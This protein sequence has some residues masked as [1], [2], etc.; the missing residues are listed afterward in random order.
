MPMAHALGDR[1]AA[2]PGFGAA[3]GAEPRRRLVQPLIL[4]SGDEEERRAI[5][6]LP[7]Q[8]LLSITEA[9]REARAAASAGIAGVLLF[10]AP[11]RKDETA[12]LASEREWLVPRAIRAIKDAVPE[13]GVATDV[14]VC[15]YTTHGQCVLFTDGGADVDATFSR[16]GDIAVAH[17]EA[18][19]DLLL[20][21][22]AIPGT[23]SAVRSALDRANL[24]GTAV[25][26]VV[27]YASSLYQ[28]YRSAVGMSYGEER[29]VQLI[30]AG[31]AAAGLAAARRGLAEGADLVLVK[32]GILALDVVAT[33]R[34]RET[35]P[36]ASFEV[37]GEH[38]MRRTAEEV[39][40]DP[41]ALAAET[42][43]V[44]VRAGADLV[45]SYDAIVA[46]E[47]LAE[48]IPA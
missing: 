37:A 36:V 15:A 16:L 32:P 41:A 7:G 8:Y 12:V 1:L 44:L 17:A 35:A 31:D 34:A 45:V 18:G 21:T 29:A 6:S 5:P 4:F 38:G 40:L 42:A 47:R 46:A 2:R 27:K 39:G 22:G 13:L 23:T 3:L 26:V 33:L 30:A 10:A 43:L 9:V 20:P 25:A 48:G 11:D 28:P 19:A 24:A 14:C